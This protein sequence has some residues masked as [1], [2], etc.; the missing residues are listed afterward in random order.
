MLIEV[1]VENIQLDEIDMLREVNVERCE[2]VTVNIYYFTACFFMD[3][4][5]GGLLLGLYS[6]TF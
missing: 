4:Y 1:N 6:R 5:R 3:G 2:V